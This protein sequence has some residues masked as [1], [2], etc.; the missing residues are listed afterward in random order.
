MAVAL[1]SSFS[2]PSRSTTSPI[3]VVPELLIA[4]PVTRSELMVG[5][6]LPYAAAQILGASKLRTAFSIT[7]PLVAPDGERIEAGASR[8]GNTF[9]T[10]VGWARPYAAA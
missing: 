3:T 1:A 7:A 4:T 6:V 10:V 2:M 8:R 9:R 5:K